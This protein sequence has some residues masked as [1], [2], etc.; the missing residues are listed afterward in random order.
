[1]FVRPSKLCNSEDFSDRI[2][3]GSGLTI[4]DAATP[5]PGAQGEETEAS[6]LACRAC[7]HGPDLVQLGDVGRNMAQPFRNSC[8]FATPNFP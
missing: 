1:M 6:S 8:P 4:S 7:H 2:S 5:L 3:F